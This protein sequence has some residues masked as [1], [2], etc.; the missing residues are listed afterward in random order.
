MPMLP[1][2]IYI[3]HYMDNILLAGP[4]G[5]KVQEAL[6]ALKHALQTAGLQIAPAKVQTQAP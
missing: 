5:D 6:P 3:D 1:G 4:S 2:D